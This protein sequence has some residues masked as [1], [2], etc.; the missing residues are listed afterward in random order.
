M[1]KTTV[2]ASVFA[3]YAFAMFAIASLPQNSPSIPVD[4]I[5]TS[6]TN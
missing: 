6:S 1:I 5:T 3:A 2:A 4:R